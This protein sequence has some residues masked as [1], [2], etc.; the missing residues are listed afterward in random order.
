MSKEI[1]EYDLVTGEE[2]EFG[3]IMRG[4]PDEHGEC[5]PSAHCSGCDQARRIR[6]KK[7]EQVK[8][9]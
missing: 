9:A 4:T 3:C 1:I 5:A 6:A 2:L 7:A 8:S